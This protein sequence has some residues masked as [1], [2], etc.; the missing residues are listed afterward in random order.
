MER[1]TIKNGIEKIGFQAF[2]NCPSLTTLNQDLPETLK[3]IEE[4]AFM[5]CKNLK[6]SIH[7]PDSLEVVK[8][9][10]FDGTRCKLKIDRTRTKPITF[11]SADR[12][13]VNAH[14]ISIKK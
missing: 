1:V 7:V 2:K 5:S 14:V 3:V 6:G 13:W 12:E 10:A 9:R 8:L 4:E 11:S